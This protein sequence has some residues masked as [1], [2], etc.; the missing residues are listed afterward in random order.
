LDS[1]EE[2]LARIPIQE[3]ESTEATCRLGSTGQSRNVY[4]YIAVHFECVPAS[5]RF[6]LLRCFLFGKFFLSL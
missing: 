5:D 1:F 6:G 3:M 2:L 4:G